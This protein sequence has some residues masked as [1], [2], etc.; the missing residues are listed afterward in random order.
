MNSNLLVS[1]PRRRGG[2]C[3]NNTKTTKTNTTPSVVS[4]ITPAPVVPGGFSLG[5]DLGDRSHHVCVLGRAWL[6]SCHQAAILTTSPARAR[7]QPVASCELR[8]LE[9]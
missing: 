2:W 9:A 8:G 1:L 7:V 5:L 6:K 4:T 3:A